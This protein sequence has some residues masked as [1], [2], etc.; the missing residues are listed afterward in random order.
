M[1][2]ASRRW[3]KT[4]QTIVLFK[5]GGTPTSEDLRFA[6]AEAA[7]SNKAVELPFRHAE[8][9]QEFVVKITAGNATAGPRWTLMIGEHPDARVLWTKESSEVIVIQ[10]RIRVDS[11]Q[12]ARQDPGPSATFQL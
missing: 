1:S 6:L 4:T 5:M 7:R 3:G 11:L 10:S 9:G 2:L 8:T 12:V